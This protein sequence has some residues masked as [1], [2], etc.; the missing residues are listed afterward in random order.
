MKI[1]CSSS[2]F[3]AAATTALPLSLIETFLELDSTIRESSINLIDV[4]T[5]MPSAQRSDIPIDEARHFPE[6][7]VF[8]PV[9]GAQYFLHRHAAGNAPASVH[10]HFFQRWQ[11]LEL[12]LPEAETI[13]THL[14]ALELNAFGEPQAWFVVNQWVVGDYWQPAE[15]TVRLFSDWHI[16]SPDNGRGNKVPEICHRWLATYLR[17]NLIATIYPLLCERD[18]LLDKLVDSYP[19]TNVLDDRTHEV[20][21]YQRI[22]FNAQSDAWMRAP[23]I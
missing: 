6:D 17:L 19:G 7:D 18:V 4:L 3:R 14:A 2:D 20:L 22:D 23:K 10:I 21:S 11:P 12:Q 1:N 13:S 5:D 9:T 15:D 8:D 16:A